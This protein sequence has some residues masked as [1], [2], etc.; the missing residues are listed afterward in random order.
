MAFSQVDTMAEFVFEVCRMDSP[1]LGLKLRWYPS[2]PNFR[3]QV[4]SIAPDHPVAIKNKLLLDIGL[5]HL[6]LVRGDVVLCVNS[7]RDVINR[8]IIV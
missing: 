2:A 7:C 8:V 4:D 5:P 6:C 3:A 1:Q